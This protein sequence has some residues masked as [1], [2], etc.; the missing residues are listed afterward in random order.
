MRRAEQDPLYQELLAFEID[1]EPAVFAFNDRLGRENG[2]HPS[3]AVRVVIEYKRFLYLCATQGVPMT[4]SR[5]VDQV[6]H[7]HLTY[8]RSY[9]QRL[10]RD[11]L[12][13]PLHHHPTQGG[14]R[15]RVKFH[16]WYERTIAAYR[17]TFGAE[18]PADI[19]PPARIRFGED[20]H[21]HRVE[22]R[23]C[24]VIPKPWVWL[25]EHRGHVMIAAALVTGTLLLLGC[26]GGVGDTVTIFVILFGFLALWCHGIYRSTGSP[27]LPPARGTRSSRV[28]ADTTRNRPCPRHADRGLVHD[29][30]RAVAEM[31]PCTC[32][33]GCGG[34]GD[35][36]D[37][38]GDGDGGG[39][40]CGGGCGGCG[41][42]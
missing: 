39:D 11:V 2:W 31:R 23:H 36:G 22:A 30:L 35:G 38:D 24:W 1:D 34:G 3:H 6:W 28:S 16:S 29:A 26:R 14:S 13:A 7:L 21:A 40:G 15:E 41:C 5:E 4:P 9:W 33:D 8:T 32:D 18:P 27:S 20:A 19:W 25:A 12:P 10:C 42:G 37:G 17:Q